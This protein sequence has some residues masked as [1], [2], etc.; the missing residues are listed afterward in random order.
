MT[1]AEKQEQH[2]VWQERIASYR[3]SGLGGRK[4]C[5]ANGVKYHQLRYRIE[6]QRSCSHEETVPKWLEVPTHR[7]GR[8]STLVVRVGNAAI[9]VGPEFDADLLRSV[10]KALSTC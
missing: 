7:L 6:L 8:V 9:E 5:A 4:W 10:V 1:A 3:A 2:D